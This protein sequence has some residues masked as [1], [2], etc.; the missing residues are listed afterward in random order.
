MTVNVMTMKRIGEF[1]V[2]A[3]ALVTVIAGL[4]GAAMAEPSGLSALKDHDVQ[5]PID[6]TADRLEVRT[7][8]NVAVFEGRVRAD[9]GDMTLSADR[10]TVYYQG[11]ET[12]TAQTLSGDT[13]KPEAKPEAKPAAGAED[14]PPTITRIDAAGS[15]K[16]V[17]PSETAT[18]SWGVY[19]MEKRIITVGGAVQLTRG[20]ATIKGDRMQVDLNSGVTKL[21]AADMGAGEG[22]GRVRGRF[23]PSDKK[24]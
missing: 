20:D 23:T 8:D 1:G 7:K 16:L 12:K 4:G 18:G 22:K 3:A 2:A 11:D 21:D 15:V 24:G 6:I 14:K 19:D 17:S 13:A 5:Q 9:Q 10:V